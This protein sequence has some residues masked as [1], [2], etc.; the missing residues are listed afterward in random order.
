MKETYSHEFNIIQRFVAAI[1]TMWRINSDSIDFK[2]GYFAP[3]FG[4]EMTLNRGFYF[5]QRYSINV[6]FIWGAFH[7]KLPIK[8]KIEP[9]CGW[10][11]YGF[12]I[13]E[14][15]LVFRWGDIYKSWGIP[16][17]SY[18]FDGHTVIDQDGEWID[19]SNSW[20]NDLI[21]RDRFDYVYTLCS[22][23]VQKRIATC[24]VSRRQ[25]HRKWAPLFKL[26]RKEIEV[27]FSGEV[28][29]RSGGWKGGTIGCGYEM[30][31]GEGVEQ[32]LRRME[33]ERKFT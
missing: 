25:W 32:C 4:L 15:T 17:V 3:K 21:K 2:W 20:D 6:S 5:S 24:H 22:G 27:E 8:T 29:E 28:G 14:N 13:C 11:S 19:G 12:H 7:I 30:L 26:V 23:E 18:V 31:D 10:L 9:S 1:T 33:S 16:F